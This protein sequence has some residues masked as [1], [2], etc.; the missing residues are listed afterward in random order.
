MSKLL[1]IAIPTY[2]R[3]SELQIILEN[4]ISQITERYEELIEIVVS[5]NAS[6]D[7]TLNVL[8]SFQSKNPTVIRYFVN[9]QNIGFGKNIQSLLDNISA[10]YVWFCGDDDVL[11]DGI[12]EKIINVLNSGCFGNILI[13]YEADPEGM[14]MNLQNDTITNDLS[15]FFKITQNNCGFMTANIFRRELVQ[16]AKFSSLTWYH[17]DKLI[18]FPYETKSYIISKPYIFVVR[19]NTNNW[20]SYKNKFLFNV[21]IIEAILNSS[22]SV[23]TK[24]Q[25]ITLHKLTTFKFLKMCKKYCKEEIDF[26][27]IYEKFALM[28]K[29]GLHFPF[30]LRAI[31]SKYCYG[32]LY[33]LYKLCKN[34]RYF[35]YSLRNLKYEE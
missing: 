24:S 28:R 18:N 26:T 17:Y 3:A 27:L 32:L 7:K 16:E 23:E 31:K 21:E 1:A 11:Y 29:N 9:E 14:C 19:P 35:S 12:V 33:Y 13:N 20:F 4:L 6:N 15:E 30:F 34:T 8:T 10:E 25:L 2:N 22:L 5:D